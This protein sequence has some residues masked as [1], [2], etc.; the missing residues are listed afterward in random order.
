[1]DF[2]LGLEPKNWTTGNAPP[3]PAS[4]FQQDVN[5]TSIVPT[6][7]DREE[8]KRKK[9]R[10]VGLG[11]MAVA[12]FGLGVTSVL[13]WWF[14]FKKPRVPRVSSEGDGSEARRA[15]EGGDEST[16]SGSV[17][18]EPVTEERKGGLNLLVRKFSW[19]RVLSRKPD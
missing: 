12:V 13:V 10:D 16:L 2:T 1:M 9:L 18:T 15:G 17:N 4:E 8:A 6:A 14:W 11:L 3:S 19:S 7:T 5:P